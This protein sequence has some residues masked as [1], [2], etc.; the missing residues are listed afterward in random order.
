[1]EKYSFIPEN[2]CS[3]HF[4]IF[5]EDGI[6]KDITIVGGCPGNLLGI[7]SLITGMKIDEV[8][9]KFEG[10]K[11][12]GSK[13]RQTSCPDQIALALKNIL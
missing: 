9:K 11:C 10:I 13:T 7:K 8:I 1:M 5:Y 6:V 4:D 2:V 3:H 12:P